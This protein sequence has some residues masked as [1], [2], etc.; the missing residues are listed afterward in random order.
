LQSEDFEIK[1]GMASVTMVNIEESV[2]ALN[3]MEQCKARAREENQVCH[4]NMDE[5]H[6]DE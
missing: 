2:Y 3:M 6:T 4:V 1:M 5:S